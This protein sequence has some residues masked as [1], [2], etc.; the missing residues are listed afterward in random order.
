MPF[1]ANATILTALDAIVDSFDSGSTDANGDIRVY[2]GTAPA[3]ADA[4]LSG[5]T[6]LAQAELSNPAFGSATDANPGGTATMSGLPKS[7]SS[8][9][10]T[11]TA[12]FFRI[13]DRN[14]VC[15][16]QGTVGTSGTNMVVNSTAFQSGATFT[17]TAFTITLPES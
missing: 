13:F 10:A 2:S 6:L 16:F 11:G 3:D 8:I 9:D 15:R 4:S 12:S 7:D 5:N 17:I 14:N 1:V